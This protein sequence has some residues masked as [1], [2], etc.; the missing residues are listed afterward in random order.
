MSR[1]LFNIGQAVTINIVRIGDKWVK[2]VPAKIV[3]VNDPHPTDLRNVVL[4]VK[5]LKT[6]VLVDEHDMYKICPVTPAIRAKCIESGFPNLTKGKRYRIRSTKEHP[7]DC[8]LLNDID[9]W[10]IYPKS[11]F[12]PI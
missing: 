1:Y 12:V 5:G 10:C 11:A 4:K 3:R 7:E 9:V 8:Y 2:N 6:T